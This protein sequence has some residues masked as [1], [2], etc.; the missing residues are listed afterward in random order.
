MRLHVG[1]VVR[2]VR[3]GRVVVRRVLPMGTDRGLKNLAGEGLEPGE[4]G[5]K[6]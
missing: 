5:E 3:H 4:G 1:V 6:K 2:R